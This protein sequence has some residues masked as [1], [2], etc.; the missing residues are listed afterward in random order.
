VKVPWEISLLSI[1]T[2]S[3][4]E[5]MVPSVSCVEVPAGELGTIAA[6]RLHRELCREENPPLSG[7]RFPKPRVVMRES[8]AAP[9]GG[10]GTAKEAVSETVAK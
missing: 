3:E 1:G 6:E 10:A 7:L 5:A 2:S 4:L 8:V 9:A